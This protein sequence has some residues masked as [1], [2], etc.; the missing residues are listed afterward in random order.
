MRSKKKNKKRKSAYRRG[1]KLA[2]FFKRG[3]VFLLF[4]VLAAA[5]V[6]G[7]KMFAQQFSVKEIVVS[8]NYHLDKKDILSALKIK[9]GESLLRLDF[10]D[11]GEG[12]KQNAWIK[13][14]ALRKQFPGT[15]VIKVKEAVPKALLSL[16]KRLYLIDE[17]GRMLERIKG[18][19]TPFLPVIKDIDPENS[20]GIAEALKLVKALSEKNGFIDR[21]YIEIG[22]ESYGLTISIDGEFIKVGYGRYSEKFER[23]IEL[24]PEIR[25]RGVPVKYVDLRFKDSVIVKP[26]K[27]IKGDKSS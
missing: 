12:L 19:T 20:K 4:V 10:K 8:G 2:I 24:E 25:K 27:K 26:M 1:E 22:L 7:L 9:K 17:D 14:V 21:G 13:N 18:E 23:W 16:K 5:L 6:L 15:V 3:T 11:I